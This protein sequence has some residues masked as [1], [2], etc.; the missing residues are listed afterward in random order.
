MDEEAYIKGRLDEQINWYS[1]K[2]KKCQNWFKTLR[3]IEILAAATI[4][5]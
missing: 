4:P 1:D 3:F 5:F 2:S